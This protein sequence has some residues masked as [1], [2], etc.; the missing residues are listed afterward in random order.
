MCRLKVGDIVQHFKREYV[1]DKTSLKHL[2]KIISM[3][4]IDT[5]TDCEIVIY[6]A[7][8]PPYKMFSR[9]LD[10]FLG[11]VDKEKYPDIVQ[12]YRLEKYNG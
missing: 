12:K 2:Y 8:Y 11:E 3:D 9:P 10:E 6:Q 7:L 4:A 1:K 5:K